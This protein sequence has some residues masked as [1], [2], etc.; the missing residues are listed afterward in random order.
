M[1]GVILAAGKGTRMLPL[2]ERR[3]KPLVPVLDRPMLEHIIVGA[4]DAGVDEIGVIVGHLGEQIVEYFGDGSGLGMRIEYIWQQEA[5]GTGHAALLAEGFVAGE[6]FFMSWGD[7]IVPPENY[8]NVVNAFREGDCDAV[9]SLNYVEDPY[10]GAAVYEE[11]GFVVRIQEKPP[12]GTATTNWNNA[13]LFV[14][15][16]ELFDRLRNLTPSPR[17]ELELP[18]AVQEMIR[19]GKR[20]RA[21]K[22]VGYWSDV[23]RPAAVLSLNSTIMEYR[24]RDA[25]GIH[26]DPT[27]QINEGCV[28]KPPVYVGPGCVV[29]DA[30]IGPDVTLISNCRVQAGVQLRRSALFDGVRV[31]CGA[32]LTRCVVEEGAQVEAGVT[33]KG[34]ADAPLIVRS[35]GTVQEVPE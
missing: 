2:T 34:T 16:A 8:K 17:G 29:Q 10:Q 7:I 15:Q 18:D 13:G 27:A 14:Y 19:E 33:L 3:P 31:G 4:R 23:A 25:Y 21:V 28:V 32:V 6:P 26:I 30:R 35:D 11:D 1:K 5:K 22:L 24:Y 12:K 20:I 9:L